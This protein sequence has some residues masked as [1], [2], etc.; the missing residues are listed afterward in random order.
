MIPWLVDVA[1]DLRQNFI[2]IS[3]TEGQLF[4]FDQIQAIQFGIVDKD[5]NFCTNQ[6]HIDETAFN[7]RE[8]GLR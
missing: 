6:Y 5:P 7:L 4:E 2:R 1:P 3:P 8:D